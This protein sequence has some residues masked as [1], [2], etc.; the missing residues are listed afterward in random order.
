ML[1]HRHAVH[2]TDGSLCDDESRE[3]TENEKGVICLTYAL[4]QII[5]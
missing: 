1:G 2:T 4:S 3:K 5:L